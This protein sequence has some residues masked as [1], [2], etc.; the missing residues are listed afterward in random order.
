MSIFRALC[1]ICE[2]LLLCMCCLPNRMG[3]TFQQNVK[4]GPH[5][6]GIVH[7]DGLL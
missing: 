4:A 5:Q 3:R 6:R 2:F 7:Q 1:F